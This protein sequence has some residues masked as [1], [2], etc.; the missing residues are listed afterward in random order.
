[1]VLP[2]P[3]LLE[4]Q[5]GGGGGGGRTWGRKVG[6]AAG[7]CRGRGGGGRLSL[8]LGSGAGSDASEMS[9]AP[10]QSPLSS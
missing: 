7:L 2:S 8:G 4:N 6:A 1:M 10:A 5:Q 9:Y 3:K